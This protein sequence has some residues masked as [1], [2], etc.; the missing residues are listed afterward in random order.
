[1]EIRVI[2]KNVVQ[3]RHARD[4]QSK[5]E[6]LKNARNGIVARPI[7]SP[8]VHVPYQGGT[9]LFPAAYMDEHCVAHH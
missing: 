2:D 4:E 9:S 7:L 8:G 6:T 1:M 5:H 3:S